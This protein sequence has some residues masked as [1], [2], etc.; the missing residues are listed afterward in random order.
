MTRCENKRD[1]PCA[2]VCPRHGKC[3]AC[4]A[5]HRGHNEGGV[6]FLLQRGRDDP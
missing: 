4:V 1:C 2:Y 3:C 5:R 6:L